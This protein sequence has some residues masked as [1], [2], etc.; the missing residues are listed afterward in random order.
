M[1]RAANLHRKSSGTDRPVV[2]GE[3]RRH[4]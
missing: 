3:G 4:G 1:L 2:A